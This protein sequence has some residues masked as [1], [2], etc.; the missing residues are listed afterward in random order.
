MIEGMSLLESITEPHC[1]R[2]LSDAQ[3]AQLAEQ[4]R[5]FLVS[6]VSKTGGHLGPNLG[7]V[8]LTIALHRVFDSPHD[9]ILF[10]T[11]HQSYVHKIL[12]GR[13]DQFPRLRQAGGLSGYP[14][15]E[16]SEH[17]W[18]E[19]SHASTSLS[20]AQG[21]A[22][23]FRLSGQSDRCVVAVIGDGALTGGMAWEALN[24]IA[25][26]DGLRLVIV[27]NDNGRSYA[28]TIGGFSRYLAG[29]RTDPRY[30][31]T[32]THMKESLQR[33]PWGKQT[34][35]LLHGLKVGIK[36][37][38]APQ[39]LFS[40]LGLKYIGPVDGHDIEA[41]TTALQ[42]AKGYGA[43]VI[44]HAITAK[45][46]GYKAAEDYDI[47]LFHSVGKINE[48]TGQ[49]LANNEKSSWTSVFSDEIVNLAEDN[50]S[51]VA[52]TAA[53][54]HPVGLSPFAQRW[55]DRVFDVGIAEQ[56]MLTSAAGLA[57]AS[58]HPVVCV[59]STFLNRACDQL[60]MDV[61]LH[62]EAVTVVLDR[63][64]IT[65]SDGASHNGVWDIAIAGLVPD[66]VLY[67]PRDE[68]RLRDALGACVAHCTGPSLVRFSKGD[69]PDPLP[70]GRSDDAGD[71]LY[72]AGGRV[73]IVTWGALAAN[74]VAAATILA[75]QRIGVDVIDP[76]R[77]LPVSDGLLARLASYDL[78]VTVEDDLIVNGLGARLRILA[79]QKAMTTPIYHCGIDHEYLPLASRDE[80]LRHYGLDPAGL[81]ETVARLYEEF[82]I[83]VD[84]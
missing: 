74:A 47:D 53:M 5:R 69:L 44:V 81:A 7:V 2:R 52:L 72:E 82:S 12:T 13:A 10:D 84:A 36:D 8:E 24:N 22:Q 26:D 75:E 58:L 45:G 80:L 64:G 18:I 71:W 41:M 39:G 73:L 46:H 55:P 61:G 6:N 15:R 42:Q 49:P 35:D 25:V 20:W 76:I 38:L 27:V 32:L 31:Q 17:D 28:P 37:V 60:I 63:S 83:T 11:G 57:A 56:H 62:H 4:I 16:E 54:L 1:V 67:A 33:A 19:N 68:Q 66:L 9:P 3:L 21:L 50:P 77:A 78:V 29:I 65:G 40:D 70:A 79:D 43:P 14:S 34:Y 23:G 48:L 59:Y 51:I 30:E